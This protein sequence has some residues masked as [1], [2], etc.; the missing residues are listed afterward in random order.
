MAAFRITAQRVAHQTVE[1]LEAFPH[2]G[3]PSRPAN[4]RRRPKPKYRPT[5]VPKLEADAARLP[6]RIRC[7]PRSV[8]PSEVPPTAH[9]HRLPNPIGR[10]I[11]PPA[12][13]DLHRASSPR[14]TAGGTCPAPPPTIRGQRRTPAAS[15]RSSHTREPTAPLPH[16]SAAAAAPIPPLHRSCPQS[17]TDLLHKNRCV[18][19]TEAECW[20]A[21]FR[22]SIGRHET[23]FFSCTVALLMRGFAQKPTLSTQAKVR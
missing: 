2:V 21:I 13:V 1:T 7:L 16:G 23:A 17:I 6:C 10:S 3:C 19:L 5:P 11:P 14:K 9:C 18:A 15:T 8:A 22:G 4:P 12:P 20:P